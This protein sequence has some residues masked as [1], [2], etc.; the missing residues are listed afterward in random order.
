MGLIRLDN[1]LVLRRSIISVFSR[2][3]IFPTSCYLQ[4]PRIGYALRTARS[5]YSLGRVTVQECAR[6]KGLYTVRFASL[7]LVPLVPCGSQSL[8]LCSEDA[9]LA[10]R[11]TIDTL[12]SF[13][14]SGIFWTIF[15]IKE[16]EVGR[17]RWITLGKGCEKNTAKKEEIWKKLQER[18]QDSGYLMFLGDQSG[19]SWDSAIL[20]VSHIQH[21][22]F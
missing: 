20:A 14:R 12:I 22:A 7:A 21:Y 1:S 16:R 4:G 10:V 3:A 18:N 9:D 11:G 5:Y 19:V 13:C 15:T 17:R 8:V 2:I 6:E